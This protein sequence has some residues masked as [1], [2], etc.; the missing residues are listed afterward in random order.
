MIKLIEYIYA[1]KYIKG[2]I[3]FKPERRFQNV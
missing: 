3:K 1:S 2:K